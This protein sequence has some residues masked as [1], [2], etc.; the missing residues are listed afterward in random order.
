MEDVAE[1]PGYVSER[2]DMAEVPGYVLERKLGRGGEGVV[3]LGKRVGGDGKL[4][5]VKTRQCHGLEAANEAIQEA[6]ALARVTGPQNVAIHDVILAKGCDNLFLV[7][8]VM[9]Y[10]TGGDLDNY[11]HE[12]KAALSYRESVVWLNQ[13]LSGLDRIHKSKLV[14]RDLKPENIFISESNQLMI[15]DMGLAKQMTSDSVDGVE[16]TTIFMAPEVLSGEGATEK[17]DVFSLGVVLFEMLVH[18]SM[19]EPE[20]H[21]D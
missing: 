8:L 3:W 15:G 21:W 4:F 18:E 19:A 12:G 10:L 7:H 13:L 9:D 1:A 6:L 20:S 5:A 17:S 2:K 16:G 14:H 11:L